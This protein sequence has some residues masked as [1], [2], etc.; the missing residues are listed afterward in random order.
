M[1]SRL[2]TSGKSSSSSTEREGGGR[3]ISSINKNILSYQAN[4]TWQSEYLGR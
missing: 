1:S 3:V 4:M 2:H